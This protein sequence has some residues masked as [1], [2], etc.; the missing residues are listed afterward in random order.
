M[1]DL[2][3]NPAFIPAVI[4]LIVAITAYIQAH[5]NSQHIVNLM[6]VTGKHEEQ[7][8]GSFEPRVKATVSPEITAAVHRVETQTSSTNIPKVQ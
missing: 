2:W 4:S 5:T 7:L 8:N 6:R 3:S 1:S